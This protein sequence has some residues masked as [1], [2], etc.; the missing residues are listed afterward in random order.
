[1]KCCCTVTRTLDTGVVE[2]TSHVQT[3]SCQD[4]GTCHDPTQTPSLGEQEDLLDWQLYGAV[5]PQG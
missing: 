4:L 5:W 2:G 1:M 3:V